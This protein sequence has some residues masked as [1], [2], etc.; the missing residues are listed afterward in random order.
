MGLWL[1]DR[2]VTCLAAGIRKS[3]C[4]SLAAA[5]L[6]LMLMLMQM[7][8]MGGRGRSWVLIEVSCRSGWVTAHLCNT[9]PCQQCALQLSAEERQSR[10]AAML[11][12]LCL[13]VSSADQGICMPPKLPCFSGVGVAVQHVTHDSLQS[14][15]SRTAWLAE[16][17]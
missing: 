14:P 7:P 1:A 8:T 11:C 4:K 5:C 10:A 6:G 2:Y 9:R 12:H 3:C 13:L 15:R 17:E 16:E